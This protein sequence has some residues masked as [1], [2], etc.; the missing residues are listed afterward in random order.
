M[1]LRLYF[2]AIS[3][4]LVVMV[5]MEVQAA[6]PKAGHEQRASPDMHQKVG[7]LDIFYGLLPAQVT[8][9]HD[10][11]HEESRMHGGVSGKVNDYHLVVAIFDKDGKRVNDVEVKA[12][13]AELGLSGALKP[14]TVMQT[15]ETASFGNYFSFRRPGVYRIE[16]E[17][18]RPTA[19]EKI[20]R[21]LFDYR[22]Q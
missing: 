16:V 10:P 3:I 18:G 7:D 2:C 17:V 22:F 15:G 14:L 20:L 6:E 4:I 5:P 21:A 19:H 8:K 13:I 9:Q 1:N 12:S 11:S